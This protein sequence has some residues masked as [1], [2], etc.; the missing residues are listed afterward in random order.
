MWNYLCAAVALTLINT[1]WNASYFILL[2]TYFK[3]SSFSMEDSHCL[4]MNYDIHLSIT[5]KCSTSR[6]L[7]PL[8]FLLDPHSIET[9]V[10]SI[11]KWFIIHLSQWLWLIFLKL[12]KQYMV[13]CY[14]LPSLSYPTGERESK[15]GSKETRVSMSSKWTWDCKQTEDISLFI[16]IQTVSMLCTWENV[17][18]YFLK[19]TD[20][21]TECP[22]PWW[23]EI[24]RY[25]HLLGS[26]TQRLQTFV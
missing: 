13:I 9:T 6:I 1:L 19:L 21:P 8:L 20:K 10:W 12:L 2:L 16:V 24:T 5:W 26:L 15:E 14:L 23:S 17:S 22:C 7:T 4:F 11:L 18:R 3:S 25:D